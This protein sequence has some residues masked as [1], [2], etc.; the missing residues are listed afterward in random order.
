MP[1]RASCSESGHCEPDA[2]SF[3]RFVPIGKFDDPHALQIYSF[4]HG[5]KVGFASITQIYG[6]AE[7]H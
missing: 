2:L 3:E 1:E 7:C 4:Y 6:G 5:R